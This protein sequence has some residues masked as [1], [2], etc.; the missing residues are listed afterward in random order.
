MKTIANSNLQF[1][2]L[3]NINYVVTI[4]ITTFRTIIKTTKHFLNYC[5]HPYILVSTLITTQ[6]NCKVETVFFKAYLQ[7]LT[8]IIIIFFF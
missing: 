4:T 7:G 1:Y 2:C 5:I 8:K 3:H 6:H